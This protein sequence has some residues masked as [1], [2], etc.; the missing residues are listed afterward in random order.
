MGIALS[1]KGVEAWKK[2]GSI[3]HDDL[4]GRIIALRLKLK[5]EKSRPVN[6]FLASA[7]CPVGK[8]DPEVWEEFLERLDT[9]ISRKAKDDILIIGM[10]SN[11]SIGTMKRNDHPNMTAVGPH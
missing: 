9:C 7:Y 10:D 5:D 4:G 3:L 8:A 6:I 2:A 11:S 1:D